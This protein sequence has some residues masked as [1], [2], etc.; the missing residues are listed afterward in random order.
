[1]I[2]LRAIFTCYTTCV[3]L[4]LVISSDTKL[5]VHIHEDAFLSCSMTMN[6]YYWSD[7][8][9]MNDLVSCVV[10]SLKCPIL[11]TIH[12]TF[13]LFWFKDNPHYLELKNCLH[14][15]KMALIAIRVKNTCYVRKEAIWSVTYEL[16]EEQTHLNR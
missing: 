8:K 12:A 7:V 13:K 15:N 14:R 5:F 3:A 9:C 10:L 11:L 6:L 4:A 1:M 16:F 2:K